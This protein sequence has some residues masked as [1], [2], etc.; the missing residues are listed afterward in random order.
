MEKPRLI[1]IR[2][3]H[4]ERIRAKQKTLKRLS[5]TTEQPHNHNI[6]KRRHLQ[7]H[8]DQM[9][10]PHEHNFGRRQRMQKRSTNC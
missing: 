6:E 8:N 1:C 5:K 4:R 7:R 3:H 10:W 9:R 2:S